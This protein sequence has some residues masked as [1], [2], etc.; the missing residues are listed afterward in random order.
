MQQVIAQALKDANV[1][2]SDID[3]LAVTAGPGLIGALLVG[4]SSASGLA[5][6]LNKPLY[7]VNHLIGTHRSRCLG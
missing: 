7:G 5:L 1:K 3:A 6:G 2:L 4:V